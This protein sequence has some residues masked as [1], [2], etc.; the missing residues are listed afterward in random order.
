[1]FDDIIGNIYKDKYIGA[2]FCCSKSC[3][4]RMRN[5]FIEDCKEHILKICYQGSKIELINNEVCYFFV[6]INK[7]PEKLAGLSLNNYIT[8]EHYIL[9]NGTLA[10]IIPSMKRKEK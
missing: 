4:D 10:S 1:M 2:I 5:N 7:Y 3:A 8:C 6:D 9:N